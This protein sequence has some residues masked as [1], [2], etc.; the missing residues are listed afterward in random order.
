MQAVD[1]GVQKKH[2]LVL[3]DCKTGIHYLIDT[4]ADISV[5]PRSKY[6][7]TKTLSRISLYAANGTPIKIYGDK[8]IVVDIGLR[9]PF[10]WTFMIADVAQA[11]IGA[12]F[13]QHHK[14]LV[15]LANKKLIDRIT[16]L[17]AP[18]S[19]VNSTAPTLSTIDCGTK[20]HELLKDLER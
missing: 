10:T 3:K 8:Q 1:D 19:I 6:R 16:K 13:L 17:R 11:I 9:R 15:D 7:G 20:Y 12:D 14:L 2:R 4:G 5:L 18:A